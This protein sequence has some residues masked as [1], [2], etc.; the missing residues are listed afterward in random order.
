MINSSLE[1]P[2][3]V[4][5]FALSSV[6]DI[7]IYHD[8]TVVFYNLVILDT[9]ISIY[10]SAESDTG[11]C[12]SDGSSARAVVRHIMGDVLVKLNA[13]YKTTLHILLCILLNV[14]ICTNNTSF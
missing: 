10:E 3:L 9:K 14:N 8:Q 1:S 12:Y 6:L 13:L 11:K 2:R 4:C 7:T 5:Q